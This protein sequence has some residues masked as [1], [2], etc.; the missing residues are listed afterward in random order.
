MTSPICS[1]PGVRMAAG[2]LHFR[3]DS[4][5]ARVSSAGGAAGAF[6]P[7]SASAKA[8]GEVLIA[9]V[10]RYTRASS[11]LS[12]CTWTSFWR[13]TGMSSRV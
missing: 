1:A 5:M 9:S 12:G 2:S 7:A 6:R 13:G 10:G 11:A 8:A 3:Y 4:R